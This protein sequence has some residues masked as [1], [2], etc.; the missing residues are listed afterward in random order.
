[1]DYR[2]ILEVTKDAPLFDGLRPEDMT[3]A[4]GCVGAFARSFDKGEYIT[5][6][7]EDIKSV[8]L[9]VSGSVDMIREDLWGNRTVMATMRKNEIFGESF[10]CG[11]SIAAT[12]SFQASAKT[13]VLF[14][15]FVRVLHTC[16][17]SCQVH[18]HLIEN[19]VALIAEKNVRLMEKIDILSKKTLRE[20]IWA[21]LMLQAN[22]NKKGYFEIP[23]GRV[24]LAEY[25]NV[26]RSALT[27][28]LGKMRDDG[29]IDFDRNT[30]RLC[31]DTL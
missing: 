30:F 10:A 18:T 31:E 24:Q 25:L 29:L 2:E 16:S 26:D 22:G 6:S 23:L 27:R 21:Y 4:M 5:L 28:E 20:K 17:N 1:M 12:V 11:T 7:E 3:G 13:E 19:I 15:P 9:V 8:G 14:L